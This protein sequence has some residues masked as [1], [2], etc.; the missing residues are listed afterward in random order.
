MHLPNGIE[1]GLAPRGAS[2]LKSK[3]FRD[4]ILDF[5]LAP[6]GASGL[7]SV[8]G[9]TTTV[10]ACLAPRGASGLKFFYPAELG[11]PSPSGSAR[12]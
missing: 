10:L 8:L 12:S 1:L 4:A 6:R 9:S 7:K 5:C 11:R 3:A 2:G